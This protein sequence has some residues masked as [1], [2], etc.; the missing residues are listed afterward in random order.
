MTRLRPADR[1]DDGTAEVL[2]R[3]TKMSALNLSRRPLLVLYEYAG[4]QSRLLFW[5]RRC[6]VLC[7]EMKKD[8]MSYLATNRLLLITSII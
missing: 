6:N 3:V 4:T 1:S 8:F 7:W 5:S 2:M